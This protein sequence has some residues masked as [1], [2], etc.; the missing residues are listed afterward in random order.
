MPKDD[1]ATPNEVAPKL[2]N[3]RD[4]AAYLGITT[5]QLA[6]ARRRGDVDHVKIARHGFYEAKDLEAWIERIKRHASFP[7]S[8]LASDGEDVVAR[9]RANIARLRESFGAGGCQEPGSDNAQGPGSKLGDAN[10]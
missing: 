1:S 5:R 10:R 4:A 6:D 7:R 9:V 3:E 2:M 8:G